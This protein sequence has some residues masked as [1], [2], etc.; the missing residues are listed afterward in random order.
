MMGDRVDIPTNPVV[1]LS[2]VPNLGILDFVGVSR[3]YRTL[4][5]LQWS[6][7]QLVLVLGVLSPLFLR[8]I[9]PE[10]GLPE[11]V[12]LG[13][14]W[15]PLGVQFVL[16]GF[17]FM[18]EVLGFPRRGYVVRERDIT[19]RTGWFSRS[20]TTVPYGQIQHLELTQGPVARLFGLKHLKLYT[21]GG[22]GNLRI[23]GLDEDVAER[24]RGL[25]DTRTGKG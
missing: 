5:L 15:I 7:V 4:R 9:S 13:L 25:L 10:M 16:G 18:E 24:L 19:Y 21:A 20:T 1:D 14:I 11:D 2:H 17:W 6:L 22:S 8:V 12:S 23:A 3:S